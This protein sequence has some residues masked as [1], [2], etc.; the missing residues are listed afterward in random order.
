MRLGT[1]LLLA[2]FV[3]LGT[4]LWRLRLLTR[5]LAVAAPPASPFEGLV[6]PPLF[7]RT[8]PVARC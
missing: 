4:S 3:S 6:P 2:T 7:S 8:I 5:A 1:T